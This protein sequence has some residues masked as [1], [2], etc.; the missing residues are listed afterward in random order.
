MELN[1]TARWCHLSSLV[2]NHYGVAPN[3]VLLHSALT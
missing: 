3:Y 1:Q 2:H